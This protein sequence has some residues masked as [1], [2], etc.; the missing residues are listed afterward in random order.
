MNIQRIHGRPAIGNLLFSPTPRIDLGVELLWGEREN[1]NRS[2]G[3][4]TQLQLAAIYRF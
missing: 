2:N 3:Y 1:K 4:A